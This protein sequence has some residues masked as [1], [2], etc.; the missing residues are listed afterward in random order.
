MIGRTVATV[1]FGLVLAASARAAEPAAEA[2]PLVEFGVAGGGG[3]LPDYPAAGQSHF[4]AI[5]LPY[6]AYRGEIIR[7]D[8]KGL[9]RGRL[10]RTRDVEL[11][12]SL[13]GS[14]AVDSDDNDARAG[15]PDLDWMG[16]I[17]PRLQIT[18]ARAARDAK[19]D[20]EL[21]LRAVFTTDFSELRYRGFIFAP[22]LAYQNENLLGADVAA[23]LSVGPVLATS[24]LMDYFYGVEPAFQTATRPAFAADGGYLGSRLQLALKKRLGPWLTVFAAARAEFHQGATNGDSPLFRDQTTFAVGIGLVWSLWRSERRAKPERPTG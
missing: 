5:A 19:L 22:E 11:D 6:F 8:E 18:L 15:M 12:V 2:K 3:Y 24:K 9:L 16:E 7:S 21:P 10:L 1:A 17:G 20:L 4:R 13:N 14:F 23:K